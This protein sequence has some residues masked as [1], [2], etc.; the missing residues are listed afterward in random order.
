MFIKG[1][2]GRDADKTGEIL[3]KPPQGDI[4]DSYLEALELTRGD[5]WLTC[6]CKCIPLERVHDRYRSRALEND[7]IEA[8]KEWLDLEIEEI[9]P[10]IIVVM[11]AVPL[12]A[13]TKLT[14]IN[15]HRGRFISMPGKK[16][17]IF[18]IY[19]PEHLNTVRKN[20]WMVD[21]LI[22][23]LDNLKKGIDKCLKRNAVYLVF[24]DILMPLT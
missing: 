6:T 22:D 19:S 5:I 3:N 20:K 2:P 18:P 21:I 15:H 1:G 23:D 13:I 9:D 10:K 11:G 17:K 14:G 4:F 24:T 16:F 12:Y 8:C 7:E